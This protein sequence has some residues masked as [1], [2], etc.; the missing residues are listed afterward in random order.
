MDLLAITVIVFLF[1]YSLQITKKWIYSDAKIKGFEKKLKQKSGLLIC[2]EAEYERLKKEYLQSIAENE[3][4]RK[5][6]INS[7][8]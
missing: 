1:I 7:K 6:I 4:L 2:S 3:E 5:N 8:N